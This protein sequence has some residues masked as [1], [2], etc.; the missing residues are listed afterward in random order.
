[1]IMGKSEKKSIRFIG[2]EKFIFGIRELETQLHFL[3]SDGGDKIICEKKGK[4][5]II[6]KYIGKDKTMIVIPSEIE[7]LPVTAIGYGA[8]VLQ[9]CVKKVVIPKSVKKIEEMAFVGKF[10]LTIACEAMWKPLGWSSKWNTFNYHVRWG[11][12]GE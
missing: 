12:K 7:G 11:Y 3:L 6:Q 5:I 9:D 8:F 4:G 10:G 1:M 2:E